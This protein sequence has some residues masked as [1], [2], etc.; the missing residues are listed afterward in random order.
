MT[1][2]RL[3]PEAKTTDRFKLTNLPLVAPGK[4]ACCGAVDRPVVDFDFTIQ[5]YG[6]VLLCETCLAEA[7]RV[8]DMVPGSELDTVE[9]G[10][11]QSFNIQLSEKKMKAVS[12]EQFD[13]IVMAF[14]SLSDV[15]LSIEPNHPDLVAN[16][17]TEADSEVF[18]FDSG[19]PFTEPELIEFASEFTK[20][21]Y[22]ALVSERPDSVP[23]DSG[24]GTG[25]FDL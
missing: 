21:E 13:S 16:P 4:C 24:D 17:A 5:F 3:I 14:S 6:A 22:D 20:S 8:I 2:L 11:T 7:A 18:D 12:H 9:R 15:L 10:A 1:E 25:F 19:E 23:S